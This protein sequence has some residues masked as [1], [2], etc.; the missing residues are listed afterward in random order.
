MEFTLRDCTL[1]DLDFIIELK[2][3]GMKWYIEKIYGWNLERQKELTLNELNRN[4]PN[5]KI[6]V[7]D[8]KDVGTTCLLEYD[9]YFQV[10][11]IVIHPDYQNK[12]IATKILSDYIALANSKK[13]RIAIKTFKEN[14]AQK[15]YQRLGFKIYNTDNTHLHL[16]IKF[17][18]K[19]TQA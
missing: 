19:Q 13:K 3:L 4:L 5:I 17:N 1:Q 16:E 18:E 2:I 10:G 11:L 14:P 7:A 9:D 15:L 6:I 8:G 12:G